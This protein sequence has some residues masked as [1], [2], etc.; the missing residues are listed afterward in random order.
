MK[1]SGLMKYKTATMNIP[2]TFKTV[3][4]IVAFSEK[5]NKHSWFW[6]LAAVSNSGSLMIE[7]LFTK[8]M[9]SSKGV[10]KK[11]KIN[12][13]TY[14]ELSTKKEGTSSP[15]KNFKIKW[16]RYKEI[17]KRPLAQPLWSWEPKKTRK[18]AEISSVDFYEW[19]KSRI[20]WILRIGSIGRDGSFGRNGRIGRDYK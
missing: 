3:E 4:E 5:S 10:I 17:C 15:R 19:V 7:R 6:L 9:M 18:S 13:I 14:G 16:G 8:V 2:I 11:I 1:S 12:G 20:S